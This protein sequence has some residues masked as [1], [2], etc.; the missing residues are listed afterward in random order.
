M[1]S[2]T[3]SFQTKD[4]TNIHFYK[5]IPDGPVRCVVQIAHG[6]AEHAARYGDFAKE[7]ISNGYA[8]YAN[9]HRGHGKSAKSLVDL[10]HFADKNGW[11][12]VVNDLHEITKIIKEEN[13]DVPIFLL[14]HSMGSFLTKSY[15][16]KYGGEIEGVI[17]SGTS[18]DQ[19]IMSQLGLLI[20][21][22]EMTFRG[23][24]A[25]SKLLNKL[26]FGSFNNSFKPNRTEYDWLT[27]DEIVVDKYVADQFC[28]GVV[29]AGFFYDMLLGIKKA[30]KLEELKKVPKHLPIFIIAGEKDPV[31][32]YTK[33]VRK[34]I[35]NYEKVGIQNLQYKFYPEARHEILNET[36]KEEVYRDVI[37][38]IEERI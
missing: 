27:R 9:D 22:C 23:K 8:V 7:L 10:G 6:M 20:A 13:P 21:K 38:W 3:F 18:S 36:N 33:L 16:Q 12:L 17:L 2:S 37:E 15:I 32:N 11:E 34:A 25:R 4:G 28:G 26:S 1:H 5:W 14:G 19:G 35:S 30:D 24:K 31:G 29:S